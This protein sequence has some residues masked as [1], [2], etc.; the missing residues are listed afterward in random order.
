ME[1]G[2]GDGVLGNQC[3]EPCRPCAH[4]VL[5]VK[6]QLDIYSHPSRLIPPSSRHKPTLG[7]PCPSAATHD[8]AKS[9]RPCPSVLYNTQV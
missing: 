7:P 9:R 5:M 3:Q 2:M 8:E 1:S 4:G 6:S